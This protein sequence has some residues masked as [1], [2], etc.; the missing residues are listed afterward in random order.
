MTTADN[1]SDA[2]KS[3]EAASGRKPDFFIVGAPKCGTS[4]MADY[5][6][7][8]PEIFMA[9]KEMHH[10]GSDLQ[11]G[12]RFYRRNLE[13]YLEEFGARNGERCA[14]EAS[15]WYLYSRNAAAELKAFNPDARVLILLRD[16]VE[17]LHSLYFQFRFDGNEQL[18]TFEQALDAEE[19][20]RCGRRVSRLSYFPPGLLYR[21]V[22]RF[23]EQ[24]RRFQET[25]DR[26][27]L[28]I[29]VYDDLCADPAATYRGALRFLG[30]SEEAGAADFQLVNGAKAVRS[31]LVRAL[32]GDP[33]LRR[34]AVAARRRLPAW[35]CRMLERVESRLWDSNTRAARRPQI[36]PELRRRLQVEFAPELDSLS[37]LLGRDLTHWSRAASPAKRHTRALSFAPSRSLAGTASADLRRT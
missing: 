16:P 15:V 4:A 34:A 28:H 23:T 36:A 19:D 18:G 33:T 24:V 30:V 29:I 7:A 25:F 10:F 5:L 6:A 21:D 1:L 12:P 17:V 2:A 37:G 31:R 35:L 3:R 13:E 32:L 14:G 22:V 11:F 8:H 27:Q 20:R 26:R 9:R